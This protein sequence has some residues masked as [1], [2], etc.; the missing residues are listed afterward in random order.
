MILTVAR[1]P[2]SLSSNS[3]GTRR[4]RFSKYFRRLHRRV[5]PSYNSRTPDTNQSTA[6]DLLERLL[7]FDP[8]KRITA[9][10]ALTHPYF[11]TSMNPNAGYPVPAPTSMPPATY[12]Y[13][14][15][16]QLQQQQ[17][18]QQQIQ[19][20]A[21]SYVQN[22]MHMQPAMYQQ[23]GQPQTNMPPA[24]NYPYQAGFHA[25]R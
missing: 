2:K 24:A 4:Y 1:S 13:G 15:Q 9:A 16:Q 12:N 11:T 5:G 10:E 18:Q 21:S 23:M 3:Q 25:G 7:Q 20:P 6:I 17:Q 8:S 14:A 22:P 19:Q